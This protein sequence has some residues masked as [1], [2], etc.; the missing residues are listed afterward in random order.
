VRRNRLL[1]RVPAALRARL[2][3]AP[4]FAIAA[5]LLAPVPVAAAPTGIE[6]GPRA[7]S[8]PAV[9]L[10][11]PPGTTTLVSPRRS[12]GFANGGSSEP[13]ISENG[14]WVAFTSVAT[15]LVAA[16][17][18]T[19][20]NPAVFVRD[21]TTGTTIMVP[22]PSG[23]SGGGSAGEPSISAD[24]NVVAFSYQAPVGAVLLVAGQAIYAWD[25]RSG[26]TDL[27]SRT[28]K[29][30]AA[31][32]SSA[33]SVSANGRYV[34]YT[35]L[36]PSISI[37][38]AGT[39][40]DVFRYDRSTQRT[41]LVSAGPS[42]RSAGGSSTS[43]SISA[44]GSLVAFVS[45]AGDA[46]VAEDT[47]AGDQ[48]YVRD[49][50]GGVTE[51][52]SGPPGG[53]PADGVAE[54]P[55]ISANGRYVAFES[56]ASNLVAGDD[57]RFTDVFRRDRRTGTTE[58][59]SVTPAG[60]PGGDV[61]GQAAISAD[62]Q[63]V[64]FASA[65]PDLVG[66][67]TALGGIHLA[68]LATR[69]SEV[70][71][72]DLVTR[73]TVLVSATPA[74]VPG[75]ARSLI[76]VVGGGGRYVAFASTS[77]TLVAGD[78]L[79]FADIFLRDFPP[80]PVLSP[81]VLDLGVQAV[82][83]TGLPAAAVLTNTGLA[84]VRVSAASIAGASRREFSVVADACDGRTLRRGQA[85]TVSVVFAPSRPGTLTATL[86]VADSAAGSPR[87]ARLRGVGSP[88]AAGRVELDPAV[89]S[90][91]IVTIATGS[92]FPPGAVVRLRWSFGITPRLGPI[93]ADAGGRFRVQVLVLHGDQTGR[94]MLIAEPAP[95]T[96]PGAAFTPVSVPML[97]TPASV[98]PPGFLLRRLI[99]LPLFMLFRG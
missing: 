23:A 60:T 61:S 84:P 39:N 94:R 33:P 29:G 6:P 54:G 63:M 77:A 13:S 22:P 21:R 93:V 11:P 78:K 51:R 36:S 76:P 9:L 92:G 50:R 1:V 86:Q 98:A 59:V 26:Q 5:L 14:R 32:N 12:G 56:A 96:A 31:G 65:A 17:V 91:G 73:E 8:P 20:P 62:G 81:P 70:Y 19:P 49:V 97:V 55:S 43:P 52:I 46:I 58:L 2:G 69:R 4:A 82:G 44:D 27:V 41:V 7:S 38:D 83:G 25:R 99:D 42:G 28:T 45:D 16:G 15:N 34:A 53:G 35:S 74:G 90:P 80:R 79:A 66:S 10:P 48:V 87:S 72:R 67:A 85:C 24:G 47:G 3:P 30:Q 37:L 71:E 68:A 18:A 95:G 40:P 88:V 89:G 75:G 64:A 57:G